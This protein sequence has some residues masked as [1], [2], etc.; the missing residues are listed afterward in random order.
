MDV[1]EE[2]VA[3][4]QISRGA[5]SSRDAS[6]YIAVVDMGDETLRALLSPALRTVGFSDMLK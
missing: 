2:T 5:A 1:T 3:S 4:L 6:S